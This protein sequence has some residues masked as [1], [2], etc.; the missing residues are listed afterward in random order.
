MA[1]NITYADIAERGTRSAEYVCRCRVGLGAPGRVLAYGH[2]GT[3][4]QTHSKGVSNR[5][6]TSC[7]TI[8]NDSKP[9]FTAIPMISNGFQPFLKKNLWCWRTAT[10]P[11]GRSE[12]R[13]ALAG[14]ASAPGANPPVQGLG[15]QGSLGFVGLCWTKK[16]RQIYDL[17]RERGVWAGRCRAGGRRSGAVVLAYGHH[18]GWKVRA[19][20]AGATTPYLTA[21]LS[22]QIRPNP[23][24]E[25]KRY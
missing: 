13:A 4:F 14:L 18:V 11:A 5:F 10:M 24:I 12:V 8:P 20:L 25:E 19:G 7:E 21:G 16:S 23:T 1:I 3:L 6:Q 15:Y 22:A 9:Q 2:H 17:R